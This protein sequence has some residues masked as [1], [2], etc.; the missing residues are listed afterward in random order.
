[1]NI[2]IL[3]TGSVGS[4]LGTRWAKAGYNVTFGSR[5]PQ[6]EKVTALTDRCG[7]SSRACSL[8]E[9][10][11][12]AEVIL[13]AIPWA[14][15]Q[16]TLAGLGDL[17]GRVL[18]DATN[19]LKEDFSGI[20]LG[21]TTS[22]AEQIATWAPSARVVKA[23]NSASVRVMNDPLFGN[24][25]ATMFYCGDDPAAKQTV[26]ELIDS[27]QFDPVDAGPLANARYLEPLA[28]L[29]IHLAFKQGWGSN[30]AFKMLKR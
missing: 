24:Y 11:A 30:C 17:G 26:H 28:M 5:D 6:H 20:E 9:A 29:Y 7:A 21:H 25:K 13:L 12:D 23:F 2:A 15:A 18:I 16:A 3:G 14:A 8:K 19:P 4:T 27:L 1:V 22:A 10:I